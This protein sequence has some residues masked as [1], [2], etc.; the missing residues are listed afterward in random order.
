[1]EMEISL[2]DYVDVILQYWP[3]VLAVFLVATV[4]A[5]AVSFLQPSIYEASTTLVE[6]SYEYLDTP[7][8]SSRDRT[9][10]KLYPTLAK[11]AA[12]ESAVAEA[13]G[14]SLS[15]AEQAPGALLAMV[16]LVEDRD[17]PALFQIKVQADDPNKAVQIANTWAEQYLQIAASLQPNWGPQ[18]EVAARNLE[19]AEEALVA[20]ERE[21]E[22]GVTVDLVDGNDEAQPYFLLG[23]RGREFEMK[24]HLLAEYRQAHDNLLLLL[25]SAQQVQEAGG[26]V[27]DL[28]LHLLSEGLLD[29]RGQALVEAAGAQEDL[30]TFI[31]L[32]RREEAAVSDTVDEL[33]LDVEQLQAQLVEDKLELERLVRARDLAEGT[34]EALRNRVEGT[35]L[36]ETRTDLLSR[37]S[38]SKLVG[39][40][41]EMNIVLGAAMGLAG[42]VLAAFAVHYLRGIRTA[43]PAAPS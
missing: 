9:V 5:T 14:S 31:S 27:A 28:P 38:S 40:N 34:Y 39:P 10:I 8:L 29:E 22:L 2:Q 37:A 24:A 11:S 36:F 42:G 25:D 1:V 12:V 19:S 26:T 33:A 6:E 35:G 15:E 30:D 4:V 43:A 17:N 41:R 32:L 18:L 13:L 3:V 23:T 21:S 7:R 16:T 20:F